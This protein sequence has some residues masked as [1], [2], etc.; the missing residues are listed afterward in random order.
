MLS[1]YPRVIIFLNKIEH[2]TKIIVKQA[3]K[4][5]I[6]I[7]GVTKATC[8]NIDVAKVMI[9]GGVK[10]IG[11]SRIENL[12]Q[13]KKSGILTD[14]IL[15]RT[16]MLSELDDVIEYADI[17]LNTELEVIS[18]LNEKALSKKRKH[19][20]II[21][22]EMGDLREGIMK[23]DVNDIIK[24]VLKM[25]GIKL[26]GVGMNLACFGGVIPTIE[27]IKHFSLIVSNIEDYFKY[28]FEMISG[29]NSANISGLLKEVDNG[30]INNL[31]IG[32]GILRGLETINRKP[33]PN[34]YQDC[35]TL[36]CEIIE[37][38][39]KPSKPEGI[40][41]QNAYGEIPKFNDIGKIRR[42]IVA[43][44]RQDV[45]VEDLI[46]IDSNVEILGSSSDHIILNLKN[47]NY[48]VG[49]IVRFSMKYGALVNLFTSKYVNKIC[50]RD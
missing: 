39:E 9:A 50:V 21:M 3:N 1:K 47:T 19:R 28:K 48:R 30:R 42:A 31:R 13:L 24:E 36:E 22:I 7:T 20:I 38:K 46:P 32:E 5:G 18:K 16:P 15:L 14:L 45:I 40:T 29:G 26:W 44:G 41:S 25:K 23:D 4:F 37:C 49:D 27:K 8:A 35:F 43:I 6:E 10:S 12:K 33:I 2:N 11:D 34:T 17:S